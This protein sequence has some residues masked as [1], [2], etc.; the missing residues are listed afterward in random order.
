MQ[1]NFLVGGEAGQGVQTVG[2]II[3]KV[4]SRG[5][6]YVFADQDY[7]SRIRGGHNFFR[8][9]ASDGPVYSFSGAVDILI[10]LNKETFDLHSGEMGRD[11]IIL[12]DQDKVKVASSGFRVIDVPME[13]MAVE[14]TSDRLMSNSVATGAALGLLGIN[15]DLL[16]AVLLEQFSKAGKDVAE[17]NVKAARAGYDLGERN[18]PQGQQQ[19]AANTSGERGLLLN[20]NEALALGAMAAGVKFIAAYPMTPT[21]QIMEFTS[22][23]AKDYGMVVVQPEDEIAA[24]NM[25]IGAAYAGVRAMTATSGSGFCLMVEGLGL[26][27]ITETPTVVVLGQ[28][29]GPAVGLPSRTEQGELLFA[30]YAGT[31]EFPRAVFAPA[32]IEDCFHSAVH[33]F[34]LAERY[35]TLVILL[36]DHVLGTSYQTVGRPD[37]KKVTID[38]GDVLSNAEA[39]AA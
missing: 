3:A 8:V 7:E 2:F 16:S 4:M 15:F 25:V 27:G 21:T 1:I 26:A 22:E 34:N 39:E 5:G 35:Q 17:N 20:G 12:L 10:A 9:R 33:A 23:K 29:P 28:R 38:R 24:I 30:C 32:T 18:R 11:G 13:K 31:G 14:T 37:L 19:F 6:R 36:T